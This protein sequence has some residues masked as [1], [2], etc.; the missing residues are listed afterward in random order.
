MLF[1]CVGVEMW[2]V[3]CI[4]VYMIL[5]FFVFKIGKWGYGKYG[6]YLCIKID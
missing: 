2:V 3:F 5:K 6:R 1:F 4:G